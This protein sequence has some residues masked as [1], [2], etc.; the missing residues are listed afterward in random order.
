MY[1]DRTT[2]PTWSRLC[3]FSDPATRSTTVVNV[4]K[5]QAGTLSKLHDEVKALYDS[6][7]SFTVLALTDVPATPQ[8]PIPGVYVD[9]LQ[10][11]PVEGAAPAPLGGVIPTVAWRTQATYY[12]GAANEYLVY[13]QV[14]GTVY[15]RLQPALDRARGTFVAKDAVAAAMPRG[16]GAYRD[17]V[18]GFACSYPAGYSVTRPKRAQHMV[19]FAPAAEGPVLGVYRY[20]SPLDLDGEA[21]TLVDYYKGE[22]VGGEAESSTRE[23]A[24]RPA[25]IV[26][27]KG[28]MSGKDQ[29]FFVAVIKRG[30]DTFR[31]RVAGDVAQADKSKAAFDDFVK[32][33]VLMN[34]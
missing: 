24:G 32:S 22:E 20:E 10:S 5:A 33:F 4:R 17:E 14:P 30:T 16:P 19:E 26:T 11:R 27:A 9:A 28:R 29:V 25:A 12:V 21:K 15:S 6:D 7:K 8:R 3:T 13:T 18:A 31:L 34:S 1:A 23:V 2:A